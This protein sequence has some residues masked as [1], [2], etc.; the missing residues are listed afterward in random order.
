MGRTVNSSAVVVTLFFGA[1]STV[2]AEEVDPG[3]GYVVASAT[4]TLPPA[5]PT[6]RQSDLLND[7]NRTPPA[8]TRNE[9]VVT[10][11]CNAYVDAQLEYFRTIRPPDGV[12]VFAERI[13]SSLGKRDGL[14][15]PI[16]NGDDKSPVGPDIAAAAFT[17]QRPGEQA[18]PFAGY[19]FKT[20]LA[21]R[22]AALGG[23]RDYRVHGQLL[24]SFALIARPAEYGLTGFHSFSVNHLGDVYSRDLSPETNR[25]AA[26]WATFDPDRVSGRESL[27]PIQKNK[28]RFNELR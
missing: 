10:D 24:T 11:F 26:G 21:Q 22:P 2:A 23:A 18:R 20:L 13:G 3:D 7:L 1:K 17:E 8:N 9:S 6:A 14:Y 4:T 15:W 25:V 19:Y 16:G 12:H 28:D 27:R 5:T